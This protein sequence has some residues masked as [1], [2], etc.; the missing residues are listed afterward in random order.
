MLRESKFTK[1]RGIQ[2]GRFRI[3]MQ[4][5]WKNLSRS[6]ETPIRVGKLKFLM[7]FKHVCLKGDA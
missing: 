3:V 4:I 7:H 5:L 6:K 2:F 1:F